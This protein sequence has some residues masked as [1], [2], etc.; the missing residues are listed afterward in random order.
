MNPHSRIYVAG[1]DTLLGAALLDRLRAEGCDRL[2]GVPPAEPDLTNPGQ[3]EDFFGE[4]RP[5]YVFL[6]AGPSGGIGLNRA[7]PADL[8]RDN[9]LVAAHVLDAAH[10]HGVRKLL[11]LGSSC[12]YPRLAPQPMAVESLHTGPLEPTSA[13]Y[14]TA[15]LA[16]ARLCE[17]YREQYGDCFLTAI[18]ANSF[19]PHDDF[20][21]EGGH[22][23]AALLGRAH[24]ARLY[25]EPQLTVWGTGRPRREFLY[26][27]DLADACVF[28]MRH[29]DG[30]APINLAGGET[31]SVA[32]VARAVAEVVGYRGDIHFDA[33]RPDGAPLKVL[34]ASALQALGWRPSTRF[35]TALAETY[36][37]FLQHALTEGPA[38]GHAA[39]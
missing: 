5:E 9:L 25:H 20:S 2:V 24:R 37:W 22:V 23:V 34:D 29:Y 19:G 3:V 35:R 28:V 21:P 17:A 39:V 4:H 30:A 38:H 31:L 18:P 15:R 27:R 8:M 11:Y 6:A 26:S 36:D 16:G 32:A 13:A 7:R 10:R 14:A 12:G 1:G 33:A